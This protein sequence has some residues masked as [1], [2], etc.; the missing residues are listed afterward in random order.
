MSN[1]G[2]YIRFRLPVTP[3]RDGHPP[4]AKRLRV[5][6]TEPVHNQLVR[7]ELACY[8]CRQQKKKCCR[9][10]P[11]C[12]SCAA[13]GFP[14]VF[15]KKD[16]PLA[17]SGEINELRAQIRAL[18]RHF[19]AVDGSQ[20]LS[21]AATVS[22]WEDGPVEEPA[23]T[24]S[25]SSGF[26]AED[27]T[28]LT[29]HENSA[30]T[31]YRTPPIR[32]KLP[33]WADR[34][35]LVTAYFRHVHKAYPFL[36]RQQILDELG[37]TPSGDQ[38]TE[39]TP[40]VY[41]LCAVGSATLH[42]VGK[43]SDEALATINVPYQD[44]VQL[45]LLDTSIESTRIL[46]LVTIYSIFDPVGMSPWMLTGFLGRSAI[47]LGLNRKCSTEEG[48]TLQEVEA[49]HRLFWSIY[50]LDREVAASF[51]LPVAINDEN[52]NVP[53]PSVTIEE[54]ASPL[55]IQHTR[56]LQVCRNAI[57]LRDLEGNILQKIHLSSPTSSFD[58][59][60]ADRKAVVDRFRSQLD[61]WYAN[62]CLLSQLEDDDISFHDTIPWLNVRYH[63]LLILLHFPTRLNAYYSKDQLK[64][65]CL[66]IEKYLQCSVV[67]LRQQHL[68]LHHNTLN[69]IL[70]IC[71]ILVEQCNELPDDSLR[72][73]L[74][75]CIEILD[76]FSNRWST[77]KR[78]LL[79][80][81]ARKD[82]LTSAEQSTASVDDE[83]RLRDIQVEAL[84]LVKEAMGFSSVFNDLFEAKPSTTCP[85]GKVRF[86]FD[87]ISR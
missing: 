66:S 33:A 13:A 29:Y 8:R 12:A 85:T 38:S 80:F 1:H 83:E 65:L 55:R 30:I 62:G 76:A 25:H 19:L 67:L 77:A 10:F 26:E 24:S 32:L 4:P 74:D 20:I 14:C 58:I 50:A 52:I 39:V 21:P 56:I 18:S 60:R 44:C 31:T 40:L 23:Q 36:D 11:E 79:V 27:R 45:C 35:H 42:R 46:M 57:A 82:L 48:Y 5:N 17:T 68:M 64:P 49:R 51:G 61:D 6:E 73:N 3:A 63:G 69:H 53:L 78:S 41:L 86:P 2:S 47:S 22:S 71:L 28:V 87:P 59:N 81:R 7:A 54:Y 34:K 16:E 37:D 70:I 43:L 84:A 15:P 75:L 72:D 9:S